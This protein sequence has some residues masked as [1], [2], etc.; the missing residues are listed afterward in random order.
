MNIYTKTGDKGETSLYGGERRTKDD[1]RFEA[2]GTVDELNATLGLA[3]TQEG[4]TAYLK[5]LLEIQQ[6]LFVIGSELACPPDKN[7]S[8]LKLIDEFEVKSLED[9]MDKLGAE[10]QPLQN[11]ILPGGSGLSTHLHLARTV[12]RRAERAAVRLNKV[13]PVRPVLL[14]FLN[15]LSDYL[16]V[17]ARHAN[18]TLGKNELIWP[19]RN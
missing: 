3:L 8:E 2:Y 7:V 16:F 19:G 1:L 9:D 17:V 10:L 6:E 14:Q 12:C 5:R 4:A 13:D 15:R 11:F 18:Q